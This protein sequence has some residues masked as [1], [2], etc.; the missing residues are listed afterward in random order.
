MEEE[1]IKDDILYEGLITQLKLVDC[2]WYV[3][4]V[5]YKVVE[6]ILAEMNQ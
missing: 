6:V 3:D 4:I 5:N 1:E 2:A